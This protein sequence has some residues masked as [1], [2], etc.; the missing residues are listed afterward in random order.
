MHISV[1]ILA[2]QIQ[3]TILCEQ[4]FLAF[5]T[6]W[7]ILIVPIH[8]TMDPVY[9]LK[10]ITYNF[11]IHQLQFIMMD[12][13]TYNIIMASM[14]LLPTHI[15]LLKKLLHHCFIQKTIVTLLLLKHSQ[16]SSWAYVELIKHNTMKLE[17]LLLWMIKS[18][19]QQFEWIL[20][21]VPSS[22]N[23]PSNT[24]ILLFVINLPCLIVLLKDCSN[25]SIL[26][27]L[28][29]SFHVHSNTK[30]CY[31]VSG[32]IPNYNKLHV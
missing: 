25:T 5:G 29:L 28:T 15:I 14:I 18:Y 1:E 11:I 27:I 13:N 19:W 2:C 16:N 3:H 9:P 8:P 4:I 24:W 21:C 32:A 22:S 7:N 20:S 6:Q 12:C 10:Q 26:V 17:Q 31:L 30:N 23:S